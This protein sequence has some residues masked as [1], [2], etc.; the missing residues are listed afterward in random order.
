MIGIPAL[1]IV[2]AVAQWPATY[3][4]TVR[5]LAS[6]IGPFAT[7]LVLVWLT[8]TIVGEGTA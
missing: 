1:G 4:A 5:S 2:F 6:Y 8:T 7:S 3:L